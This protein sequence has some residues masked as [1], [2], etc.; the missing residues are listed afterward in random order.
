MRLRIVWLGIIRKLGK[1]AHT[2]LIPRWHT[3][4]TGRSRLTGWPIRPLGSANLTRLSRVLGTGRDTTR[5]SVWRRGSDRVRASL[6]IWRWTEVKNCSKLFFHFRSHKKVENIFPF[7]KCRVWNEVLKFYL[8]WHW[9]SIYV[10]RF[11]I[12][13]N[14]FSLDFWARW[15]LW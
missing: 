9:V 10:S 15:F 4:T 8:L 13:H 6:W 1:M 11:S 2:T 12:F 14:L 3:K 5:A 7:W